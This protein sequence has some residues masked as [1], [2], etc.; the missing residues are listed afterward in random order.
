MTIINNRAV[1]AIQSI[2]VRGVRRS[3][4][5]EGCSQSPIK[6]LSHFRQHNFGCYLLLFQNL[7]KKIINSG[8]LLP[9]SYSGFHNRGVCVWMCMLTQCANGELCAWTLH[10][11]SGLPTQS[12]RIRCLLL[13]SASDLDSSSLKTQEL[14]IK[15]WGGG[16]LSLPLGIE[17]ISRIIL[18]TKFR[19][20][21]GLTSDVVLK[22]K[23]K[24]KRIVSNTALYY[25]FFKKFFILFKIEVS[26]IAFY[27]FKRNTSKI[28]ISGGRGEGVV[29][30]APHLC[31]YLYH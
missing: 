15:L 26:F 11:K 21:K 6:R 19:E 24:I 28:E 29:H 7:K 30:N 1:R 25:K 13:V 20:Q 17:S 4:F 22:I 23:N 14:T 8:S 5:G 3:K 12:K 31:I 27:S 16:S 2:T 10:A 18:Y 9:V